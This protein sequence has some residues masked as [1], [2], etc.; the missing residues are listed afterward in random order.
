LLTGEF[1]KRSGYNTTILAFVKDKNKKRRHLKRNG[2]DLQ[3]LL[4][5]NLGNK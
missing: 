1:G 2:L 4:I 5:E 3:S